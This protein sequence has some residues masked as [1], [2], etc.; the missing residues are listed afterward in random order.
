MRARTVAAVLVLCGALVTVA[1]VGFGTTMASGDLTEQWVSET[2]RDTEFNHHAVG[3]GPNGDVVVAPVAEL[4]RDE[5]EMTDTSC[6]LVR[7]DPA[8]GE[9]TWRTGVPAEDCFTHALTEPEIG[10]VDGDGTLEVLVSTTEHALVAYSA[11]DGDEEWRVPL[12]NYG[13]GRPT[14]GNVTAAPGPEVVTSDITG[15]LVVA[16]GNGTVAWRANLSATGL[17]VR[18][19]WTAPTVGDMD[20][21]GD[22]E[23]LVGTDGGTVLLAADGT[24]EW[25]RADGAE[26]LATAQVDDDPATEVFTAAAGAVRAYDGTGDREWTRSLT[27][28]RIRTVGDADGDGAAELFAGRPDG[29]VVALDAATGDTEW[30]TTVDTGDATVA[31]PVL[32]DLT[33]DG[34]TELVVAARTG[35]V[36]VLDPASGAE[37]AAYERSVPVFTFPTLAD[38]DGDDGAEILVRYGD[39]RVVALDYAAPAG[40]SLRLGQHARTT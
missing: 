7:L 39:G 22:P 5:I 32:G 8:D 26:Y 30:T 38:V 16:H 17:S 20:A 21:D 25:T 37:L 27:N 13:Y 28:A 11:T 6:A 15:G 14:I 31:S 12:S 4:P 29:A 18:S 34:D 3:V 19:V 36:A 35:T 23:V 40:G 1:A 33:G 2:A 9:T 10:D 24:V